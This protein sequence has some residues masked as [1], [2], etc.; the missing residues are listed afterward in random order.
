MDRSDTWLYLNV[1]NAKYI[2]IKI[3]SMSLGTMMFDNYMINFPIDNIISYCIH[4]KPKAYTGYEP[5]ILRRL[6]F[7]NIYIC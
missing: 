4:F 1:Y 2:F 3:Y 5:F 7:F 6:T